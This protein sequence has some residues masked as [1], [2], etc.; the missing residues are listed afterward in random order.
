MFKQ[1]KA[2]SREAYARNYKTL[3][4]VSLP[5]MFSSFAADIIINFLASKLL[6]SDLTD[7]SGLLYCLHFCFLNL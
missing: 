1:I 5:L 6:W 4:T 3:I 2:K 7:F